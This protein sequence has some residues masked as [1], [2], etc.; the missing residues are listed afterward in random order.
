M[1]EVDAKTGVLVRTHYDLDHASNVVLSDDDRRQRATATKNNEL[2]DPAQLDPPEF[3]LKITRTDYVLK[4][5]DKYQQ[6]DV[7]ENSCVGGRLHLVSCP[8]MHTA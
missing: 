6:P 1:F 3:L 7:T 4:S 5:L 2:V 8:N